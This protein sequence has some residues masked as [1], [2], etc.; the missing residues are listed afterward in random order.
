MRYEKGFTLAEVLITLGIIG[1]VAAITLPVIIQ[2]NNNRVVETRL[3]KF[4]S[5]INQAVKMAEV[6]YGDKK[7]W[8]A[9][10]T[11]AEF[12]ENGIPIENSSEAEIWFNKYIT[13]YMKVIRTEIVSDGSL[14]VYFPDGSALRALSNT[15]RDWSFYPGNP[16]KCNKQ[17]GISGGFGICQFAFNFI[18]SSN[19]SYWKYAKDK[20]FEPWNFAWDGTKEQLENACIRNQRV[21]SDV[22]A[23]VYCTKLI[24][25]NNWKIP[26]NYPLKV[27]Y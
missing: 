4:Y 14:M 18:P 15:T 5:A 23:R 21:T 27:S 24:E 16:D 22:I 7:Y 12:D 8:W 2:K 17:Y 11:G 1:I 19:S 10:Y 3:M 25:Y 9:N 13:P 20:G 6:D 26:D